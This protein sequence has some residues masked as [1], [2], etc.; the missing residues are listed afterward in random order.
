MT[1]RDLF[2]RGLGVGLVVVA[3]SVRVADVAGSHAGVSLIAFILT[4]TGLVFVI[5]G[6]RVPAALR[7]ERS[8]HRLLAQAIRDRRRNRSGDDNL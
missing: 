3:A 5:Q 2:W 8:R 6:K 1:H 4:L 7:V